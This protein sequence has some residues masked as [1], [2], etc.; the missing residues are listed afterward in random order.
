[1]S[2]GTDENKGGIQLGLAAY[3]IWGVMPL[4]FQLLTSVQPTEIVAHRILW[5]LV[6]L[7]LLATFWRRWP[8]IRAALGTGRVLL[9]LVVTA[10]LIAVNWLVYI[11]SIVSG[12]VLEGMS[13]FDE[14]KPDHYLVGGHHDDGDYTETCFEATT[15]ADR[16][17]PPAP[18][19][20]CPAR[21][22]ARRPTTR[23]G[24]P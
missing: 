22:R 13:A 1:M 21:S 16:R 3:A 4:Y 20:E 8:G 12:H 7:G 6:L 23:W 24:P 18:Q 9:T 15:A 10:C 5:S 14:T 19:G 11:Y 2:G 17:T